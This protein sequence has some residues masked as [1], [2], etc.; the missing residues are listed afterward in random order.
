M[1]GDV[2]FVRLRGERLRIEGGARDK[3]EG[4]IETHRAVERRKV[5]TDH[6]YKC[7][8]LLHNH[9]WLPAQG[10][11]RRRLLEGA[12]GRVRL[13]AVQGQEPCQRLGAGPLR[14]Q[15]RRVQELQPCT[16]QRE[17]DGPELGGQRRRHHLSPN[18]DC[19][20]Q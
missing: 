8:D 12:G 4:G 6:E 16:E 20:L 9:Q 14:G 5:P 17:R 15:V 1:H 19:L 3:P 18:D 13:G 10:D 7:Q 11:P 2:R